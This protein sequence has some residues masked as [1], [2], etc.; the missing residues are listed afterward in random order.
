[1]AQ[2]LD[3][4]IWRLLRSLRGS[5]FEPMHAWEAHDMRYSTEESTGLPLTEAKNVARPGVTA[6]LEERIL[7]ISGGTLGSCTGTP[8]S[9][10]YQCIRELPHKSDEI[11]N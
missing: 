6:A 9:S 2:D 8:Y 11:E 10:Q 4:R 7:S 1:M 5:V 3:L